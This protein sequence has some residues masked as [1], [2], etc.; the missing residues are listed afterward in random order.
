MKR[1][2]LLGLSL[3]ALVVT[4]VYGFLNNYFLNI[5][6]IIYYIVLI[7]VSVFT[8]MILSIIVNHQRARKIKSLETRLTA[9]SS[10]S[11]HVNKIGDQ[12]FNELPIGILLY[13]KSSLT[14]KWNN[15]FAEE[16]FGNSK[17][18]NL[19]LSD[20]NGA[21]LE[22]LEEESSGVTTLALKTKKYDVI[23]NAQNQVFYF[24]DET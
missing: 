3:I 5:G 8:I 22:L 17:L 7:V 11:Y 9:W 10:L 24:F 16:I 19:K 4:I 12:A 18:E 20:L 6:D 1:Y 14:V 15:K 23:H 21:L 2:F 13:D